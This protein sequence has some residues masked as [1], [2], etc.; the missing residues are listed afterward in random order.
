MIETKSINDS[1]VVRLTIKEAGL[2]QSDQFKHELFALLDKGHRRLIIDLEEVTYIDSSFLGA[3]VAGLKHALFLKA[4]I[5]LANLNKDIL[6][7]FELIRM[8]KV[9]SIFQN[10]DEAVGS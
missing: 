3:L 4:D 2:G 5:V 6:G 10:V 8:D 7:L 1:L 9:F